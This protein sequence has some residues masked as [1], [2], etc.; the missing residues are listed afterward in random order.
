MKQILSLLLLCSLPL[1]TL[2]NNPARRVGTALIKL[3]QYSEFIGRNGRF[4]EPK[5]ITS[6]TLPLHEN[7]DNKHTIKLST[8]RTEDTATVHITK[9]FLTEAHVAIKFDQKPDTLTPTTTETTVTHLK[10]LDLEGGCVKQD[11]PGGVRH[12]YEQVEV[13]LTKQ[14]LPLE[15]VSQSNEPE[16]VES[17]K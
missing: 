6:H 16:N 7:S 12:N 14:L 8:V 5:C 1:A 10:P 4:Y 9:V 11:V 13:R 3:I 2:A 17:K 15:D